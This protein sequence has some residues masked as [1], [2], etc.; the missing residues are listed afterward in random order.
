MLKYKKILLQVTGSIAAF[1]AVALCS[2]L[3]QIG[4]EVE[5]ILSE[6]AQEFV[7]AAS[8]EGFTRKKVYTSLY[9]SGKMMA[10]IDLERWADAIL[11]YPASANT[12]SALSHGEA[13]TLIS[14]LF[15]AHEFKKPYFIAPAMN[16]AMIAHPAVI[17]N[18]NKLQSYGIQILHPTD[19]YLACGEI[20]AGRLIEPEEIITLLEKKNPDSKKI[21]ITSGGTSEPIDPVR[22]ITNFSTGETGFQLAEKL[23]REGHDVKLI[24]SKNNTTV[25]FTEMVKNELQNHSYDYLIHAAAIADYRVDQ[26]AMNK[27]KSNGPIQL[28]L[29]PNEKVIKKVRDWS[30]NKKMKLI[31]FKLTANSEMKLDEYDSDWIIHNELKD[32]HQEKHIGTIY[33]KDRLPAF[34]F[35]TK[36]ELNQLIQNIVEGNA[37]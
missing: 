22:S 30:Q 6:G 28:N 20:G 33:N 31:S 36:T 19:G 2:K 21:L 15:L 11:L 13:N 1:K 32:V 29:I 34:Q 14:A 7:G 26:A 35:Q 3:V 16:Q 17:E 10:H 4:Y 9:E 5:V 8:F 25:E 27:L 12:I 23:K 18:L 37:L 24:R